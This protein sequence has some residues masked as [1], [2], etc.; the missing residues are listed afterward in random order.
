MWQKC[1][2]FVAGVIAPISRSARSPGDFGGTGKRDLRQLDPVAAHALLPRVEHPPVVLVG[3]HDFV[4]GLERDAELRDLER[5]ARVAR[6]G[7]L[8]GIASELGRQPPAHALDVGL[9]DLPH[10]VHGRLVRDVEVALERLVHDARARTAAAVVQIDDRPVEGEGL[11]DL[12]PVALVG[13]DARGRLRR[14]RGAR[15]PACGR[16]R[17]SV[18]AAVAAS[19]AVPVVRRNPRRV[20]MAASVYRETEDTVFLRV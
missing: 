5:L 18:N 4:A 1:R 8:L 13:R 12:A 3:R 2:T 7:E 6:D 19:P 14:E 11:L 17:L 9:E 10:V 16:A 15:R 20:N